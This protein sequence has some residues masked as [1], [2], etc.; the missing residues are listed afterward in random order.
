MSDFGSAGHQDQNKGASST[1]PS[2][3]VGGI[4]A[5]AGSRWN[6]FLHG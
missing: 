6:G 4:R 3:F 1:V 2:P 5:P